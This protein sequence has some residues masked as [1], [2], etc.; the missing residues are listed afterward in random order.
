MS[1]D[2][3]LRLQFIHLLTGR[4]SDLGRSLD[5][6]LA[7]FD[8]LV[9]ANWERVELTGLEPATCWLQTSRSSQLSYSPRRAPW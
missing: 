6:P 8:R 2:L 4:W 3:G 9:E 7:A 1:A 5:E